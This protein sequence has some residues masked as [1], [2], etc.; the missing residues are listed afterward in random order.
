MCAA[1]LCSVFMLAGAMAG[2]KLDLKLFKNIFSKN[3]TS[4]EIYRCH[5]GLTS[6]TAKSSE[7][8][9]SNPSQYPLIDLR[10]VHG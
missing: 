5:A 3:T 4:A 9:D 2:N 7:M 10:G 8:I 6:T 1:S